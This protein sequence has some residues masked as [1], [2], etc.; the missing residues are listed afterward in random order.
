MTRPQ[1][2]VLAALPAIRAVID[3]HVKNA[4][5]PLNAL[6]ADGV[7]FLDDDGVYRPVKKELALS[8]ASK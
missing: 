6:V 2:R 8:Q 3:L 7:A 4:T 5:K 1:A